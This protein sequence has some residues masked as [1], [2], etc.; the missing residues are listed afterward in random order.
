MF[1]YVIR[2]LMIGTVTL[3][4]ITFLIYGLI[5]HMPGDPL[6]FMNAESDPSR[7]VDPADYERMKAAY[8]LDKPWTTAYFS[9][10]G[11]LSM[12]D[13]GRSFTHKKQVLSLIGDRIGPTLL[14]SI[15]SMLLGYGMA[16]P[17]GLYAVT[18]SNK[19]DERIISTVLFMLYSLPT[20]V[21]AVALLYVFYQRLDLL[22]LRG[23][24]SDNHD[25]LSWWG[26]IG[27]IAY[28]MVIP[29]TCY[30][31]GILAYDVRFICSNMKEVVR[32]DYIRTARA[33]GVHEMR[34]IAV[35][36]FRNTMIPMVTHV[37]LT[38]PALVSGSVILEQIF[39]WPG[40]GRLFFESI[41]TRDYPVIMGLTLVFSLMT[42]AGQ[43]LADV[44][45]AVVD[46][47]VSYG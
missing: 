7:K 18:R 20:F 38:L 15:T 25:K 45:Y 34:V 21:A 11:R 40:M 44:L 31:Y 36:A 28:H 8:G 37:G 19:L 17:L 22:P 39:T 4:F 46:P 6:T 12:L 2:R 29:V 3:L 26:R 14:L 43:L 42:L 23:I 16:I 30:T 32:Q 35:H 1:D 27:D 10:L 41:A 13:L 24:V 5:R 9:W 47:R 33:K